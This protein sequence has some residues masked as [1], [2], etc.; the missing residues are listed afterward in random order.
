[1][2]ERMVVLSFDVLVF[3]EPGNVEQLMI[4]LFFLKDRFSFQFLLV[5]YR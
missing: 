2:L 4:A 1:M 3:L 5:F